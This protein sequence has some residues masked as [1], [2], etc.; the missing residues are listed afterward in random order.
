MRRVGIY[1][2]TNPIGQHYIGKSKDIYKRW[3]SYKRDLG[4]GQPK[5]YN[6]FKDYGI[7]NHIFE[8]IEIC[9]VSILTEREKFYIDDT[10]AYHNL[11]ST[12][13]FMIKL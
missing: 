2:I 11:N 3:N 1:K 9:D 4:K 5:L 13:C 12:T 6:S 7:E 8:I 10:F